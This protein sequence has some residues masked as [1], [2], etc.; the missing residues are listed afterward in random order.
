MIIIIKEEDLFYL[1]I[2]I[3]LPKPVRIMITLPDGVKKQRY[4]RSED[5]LEVYDN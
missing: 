5:T 4:F 3:G 1:F 2:S